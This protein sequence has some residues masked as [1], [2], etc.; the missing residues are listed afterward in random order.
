MATSRCSAWV[1]CE[2]GA[3]ARTV[4]VRSAYTGRNAN[5]VAVPNLSLHPHLGALPEELKEQR[6]LSRGDDELGNRGDGVGNR[7][8]D[9]AA[10][11]VT[12]G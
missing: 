9:D 8:A 2:T 5:Q 7:A 6:P 11:G 12:A 3:K 10:A 4:W 1:D